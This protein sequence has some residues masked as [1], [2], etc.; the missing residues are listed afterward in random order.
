MRWQSSYDKEVSS[1]DY[2]GMINWIEY[3]ARD[4]ASQLN[5]A[6]AAEAKEGHVNINLKRTITT[7]SNIAREAGALKEILRGESRLEFMQR[8]EAAKR[9][10]SRTSVRLKLKAHK[11]KT[12]K[13]RVIKRVQRR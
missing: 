13:K 8:A 4:I 2:K 6:Y 12:V 5:R 7:F 1:T 11:G 10:H 3:T 9:D